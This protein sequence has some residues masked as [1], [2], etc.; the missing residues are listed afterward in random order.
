M[1]RY[2]INGEM[3]LTPEKEMT[4]H[5]TVQVK[6]KWFFGKWQ[7]LKMEDG[8]ITEHVWWHHSFI[9]KIEEAI[10]LVTIHSEENTTG[11]LRLTIQ[12]P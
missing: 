4:L 8:K 6:K 1:Y 7:T 2:R 11:L 5:Y 3:M 12:I 10:K 9:T